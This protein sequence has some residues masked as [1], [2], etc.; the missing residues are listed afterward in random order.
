MHAL[1]HAR[2]DVEAIPGLVVD[3]SALHDDEGIPALIEDLEIDTKHRNDFR[4][5]AIV[6]DR[7]WIKWGAALVGLITRTEIRWFV[8]DEREVTAD[9]ARTG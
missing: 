8:A 2:L 9:R 1:L 6:G 5:I 7:K 3:L 4:C